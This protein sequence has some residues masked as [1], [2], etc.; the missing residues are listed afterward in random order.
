MLLPLK[1][2]TYELFRMLLS[3][4]IVFDRDIFN[5]YLMKNKLSRKL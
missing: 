1:K 5:F 4:K 3:T 2:K